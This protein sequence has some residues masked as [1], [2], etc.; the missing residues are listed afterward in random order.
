MGVASTKRAFK[1]EG[2]VAV[3]GPELSKQSE[4]YRFLITEMLITLIQ[5]H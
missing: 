1:G 3:H 4:T 5:P 2:C